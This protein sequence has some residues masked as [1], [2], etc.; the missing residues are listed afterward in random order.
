MYISEER[1]KDY[2]MF[3]FIRKAHYTTHASKS[4]VYRIAGYLFCFSGSL[5]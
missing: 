1:Q 3:I 5:A 2:E 4:T